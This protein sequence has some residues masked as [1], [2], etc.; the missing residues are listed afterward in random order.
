SCECARPPRSRLSRPR[1]LPS[2]P[3]AHRRV[4]P[5]RERIA[6]N[7]PEGRYP[8]SRSTHS[9]CVQGPRRAP[10]GVQAVHPVRLRGRVSRPEGAS[11]PGEEGKAI[12]HPILAPPHAEGGEPIVLARPGD[13][14]N[15]DP[16]QRDG[17]SSAPPASCRV[18]PLDPRRPIVGTRIPHGY[19]GDG[20]SGSSQVYTDVASD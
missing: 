13:W 6:P 15:P 10:R 20:H 3:L 8:P 4:P 7:R 18:A 12:L 1:C 9:G 14:T 2:S 16:D 19:I 17:R 11:A 5:T